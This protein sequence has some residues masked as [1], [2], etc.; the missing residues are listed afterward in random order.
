MTQ[1][2]PFGYLPDGRTVWQ[3]TLRGGGLTAQ[4]LTYGATLRDLRLDGHAPPLVLGFDHFAPYIDH[5]GYFGAIVGR[6]AN[7]IK[8]GRFTLNGTRFQLDPNNGP[9]HL[10]GGSNGTAHR[11]WT[12]AAHTDHSATF[13][14][15]SPAGEMGYPG[16]LTI[17]LV[18]SLLPGG[19]LDLQFSA[20]T[21]AATLCNLAHHSYFNFGGANILSHR[22]QITAAHYLPVDAALIPTGQVAETAGTAF[23]FQTAKPLA[24]A[25]ATT[26]IDH[27][28]CLTQIPQNPGN[29]LPLRRVAALY[30][31]AI[32][33]DLLTDQPGLQ[34]YDAAR[35]NLPVPGLDGKIYGAYAGLAM[36]PQLWPNA[37]NHQDWAQPVL[38]PGHSYTQHTQF[39]FARQSTP[40]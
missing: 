8:D 17:S 32:A 3:I 4:M 38:N 6:C 27:N 14:L 28:F 35:M 36:E 34:I 10:H 12:I 18:I 9:N 15:I 13:T 21:D 22:L 25:C 30:T 5:P 16:T 19:V 23:D 7:R 33:M 20:T 24:A 31:K 29:S 2:T 40:E 37:I 26:A 11:L 1:I 39:R